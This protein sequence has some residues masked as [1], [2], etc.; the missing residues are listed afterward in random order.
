[1]LFM[2]GQKEDINVRG[3][4][5]HMMAD[6]G[7]SAGVVIGGIIMF[8]TGLNWIDPVISLLIV[9]LIFWSTWGLLAEAVRMSLAGVPRGIDIEKVSAKACGISW[10]INRT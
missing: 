4:F 9:A 6:A 2:S 8:F 10:R 1:M 3:A 7:V 5:L